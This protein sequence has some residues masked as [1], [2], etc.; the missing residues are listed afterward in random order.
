M[1]EIILILGKSGS[2]KS[3]SLRNLDPKITFAVSVD[4][5]KFPFRMKGWEQMS[6]TNKSGSFYIPQEKGAN[7]YLQIKGASEE[8]IKQG[9]KIIVIDDSQACISKEF[10]DRAYETGYQK[11]TEIGKK[12]HDLIMWARELPDNVTVY[13]LHHIDID[14][15]DKFKVKTSGK[16]LDDQTSIEGKFT[17]CIHARK[18]DDSHEFATKVSNEPIFKAPFGMFEKDPMDNDLAVVDKIIREFW[19]ME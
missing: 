14:R 16:M 7:A 4:G 6:Q 17:I 5:K 1:S 3:A 18:I 13:F 19:G 12:F 10:F 15:D 9:K 8:A 2:G 11:W